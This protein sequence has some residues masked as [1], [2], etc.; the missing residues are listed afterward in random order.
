MGTGLGCLEEGAVFIENMIAQD[1][2]SPM[3]SRFPGSVHNGPAAQIAIDLGAC[4]MN[5]A[6]TAA[7]ITF[8]SALWK[9]VRQLATDEADTALVGAVDELN[10]Y[11][12]S[13]GKRWKFW[14]R[15]TLPGEGAMVASL[16]RAD[17]AGASL[18]HVTGVRLGRQRQPFDAGRE[19]DWIAASFDLT[20][21][22]IV[23][24]G[25]KGWPALDAKYAA[26]VVAL[27][28][29]AGRNLE[30]QTYKHLCGEFHSASAF[31]FSVAVDLARQSRRGVLLYTLALRGGKAVCC[32][33][34]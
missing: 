33:A 19:A 6:P 3:P 24:S 1:E 5:S 34:P 4:A 23:L 11:P 22:D 25:A 30:H 15:Q 32:V 10:K 8:E 26:V 7:E 18:A 21:I 31:G 17:K 9:C 16:A 2:R 12:L 20:G 28:K 29:R 14:D 27:S 13:I